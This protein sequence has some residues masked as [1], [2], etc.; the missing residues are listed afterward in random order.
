MTDAQRA[1]YLNL[2]RWTNCWF[3]TADD[4]A[5]TFSATAKDMDW[6]FGGIILPDGDL[7]NVGNIT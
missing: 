2:T 4:G 7:A 3:Y 1:T 6:K 5:I